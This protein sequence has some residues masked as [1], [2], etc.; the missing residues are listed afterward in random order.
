M[1]PAYD[2][3]DSLYQFKGKWDIPSHCGL[4][5]IQKND[6][7]IVIAT[8]LHEDNPGTAVTEFCSELANLIIKEYSI[9][10]DSLIFIEHTPELKSKLSHN[11]ET[12]DIVTFDWDGEKFTHPDWKRITRDEFTSLIG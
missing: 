2:F 11:S 8:D 9:K 4:K 6:K 3:I 7:H 1:I 10:H 12:F 5:I